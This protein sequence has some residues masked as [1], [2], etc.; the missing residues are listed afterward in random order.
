MGPTNLTITNNSG[1]SLLVM[2]N[3]AGNIGGCDD[4]GTFTYNFDSS[5]TNNTNAVR[6][7]DPSTPEAYTVESGIS[8]SGGGSGFDP[9]YQSPFT[10]G[11]NG[12]FT[13]EVNTSPFSANA[14]GWI[15]MEPFD[16]MVNGG[17]VN[18]NYTKA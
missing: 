13:G 9:G 17:D 15:E 3:Q 5:F 10:I 6:F 4:G 11:A 18:V 14:N 12:I 7:F 2:N 8:W 16:L 1:L